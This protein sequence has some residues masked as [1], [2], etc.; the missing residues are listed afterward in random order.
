MAINFNGGILIVWS[1]HVNQKK[2]ITPQITHSW[3]SFQKPAQ[4][5]KWHFKNR[6]LL[7]CNH[8]WRDA[9]TTCLEVAYLPK[10]LGHFQ[11]TA[12]PAWGCTRHTAPQGSAQGP[13]AQVKGGKFRTKSEASENSVFF[14][15]YLPWEISMAS[16]E[17]VEIYG[18][19]LGM[20]LNFPEPWDFE[21]PTTRPWEFA[22]FIKPG[23]VWWRM[24]AAFPT[25]ENSIFKSLVPKKPRHPLF[26]VTSPHNSKPYLD[27]HTNCEWAIYLAGDTPYIA[28]KKKNVCHPLVC[29]V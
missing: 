4:I 6:Q 10:P 25:W 7:R 16:W 11:W 19:L 22:H 17:I 3:L 26:L 20:W 23:M 28:G 13:S 12:S 24:K 1:T 8:H 18:N 21:T 5:S 2:K 9:S 29:P 14:G 27:V 15:G